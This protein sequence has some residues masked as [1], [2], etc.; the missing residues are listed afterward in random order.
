[1]TIMSTNDESKTILSLFR[2]GMN[3]I[4]KGCTLCQRQSDKVI[5]LGEEQAFL[6]QLL[7]ADDLQWDIED[8]KLHILDK[9]FLNSSLRCDRRSA[10]LSVLWDDQAEEDEMKDFIQSQQG[11]FKH[12]KKVCEPIVLTLAINSCNNVVHRDTLVHLCMNSQYGAVLFRKIIMKILNLLVINWFDQKKQEEIARFLKDF[13][14]RLSNY[15]YR[16]DIE[17]NIESRR[18]C[19]CDRVKGSNIDM[20]YKEVRL[21]DK[22]KQIRKG[23]NEDILDY[24]VK[25]EKKPRI[26]YASRLALIQQILSIK[27][28][29]KEF[30][31][32]DRFYQFNGEIED[33]NYT[34]KIREIIYTIDV[35]DEDRKQETVKRLGRMIDLCVMDWIDEEVKSVHDWVL[36]G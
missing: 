4:H 16:F 18:I 19:L 26:Y 1:M 7:I 34:K 17:K 13:L 28:L 6:I 20:L 3:V 27:F 15:K 12:W 25:L 36:A 2:L 21:K 24:F 10:E 22:N 5:C 33:T 8:K 32:P 11:I 29:D 30:G 23:I 14:E 35:Q 9:E 31:L